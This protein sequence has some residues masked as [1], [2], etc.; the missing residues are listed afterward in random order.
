MQIEISAFTLLKLDWTECC[1]VLKNKHL[2]WDWQG[3]RYKQSYQLHQGVITMENRV[4]HEFTDSYREQ[5]QV[6]LTKPRITDLL[7][8]DKKTWRTQIYNLRF[9]AN[10]Q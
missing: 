3:E 9:T 2:L 8:V 5:P 4:T 7:P 10:I 1:H 6:N